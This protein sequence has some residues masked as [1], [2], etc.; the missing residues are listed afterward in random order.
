MFLVVS[1]FRVQEG[2]AD[3]VRGAFFDRPQ[4]V[5]HAPG[6]LGM[7]VFTDSADPSVFHLVTRWTDQAS[8]DRWH[9]SEAYH[10]SVQHLPKG[11]KIVAGTVELSRLERLPPA[12][13]VLLSEIVADT[14]PVLAH[15][16][17]TSSSV[18]FLVA[19]LDGTIRV[20]NGAMAASL[21]V[22]ESDLSGRSLWE[23]LTEHDAT[24]VRDRVARADRNYEETFLLN[25]VDCRHCPFTLE[26]HC[27]VQPTY[28]VLLGERP[29]ERTDA[30]QEGWL[31][32]NN[33]LSLLAR[34]NARQNKELQEA[35]RQLQKALAELQDSHWH[36]KK[37]QE[38][39]PIC[40]DCG[41]VK[42][43]GK[44]EGVVEYLKQNALF[45]SHGYC[46]QCLARKAAEW[47]LPPGYNLP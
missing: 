43:G 34:E 31:E 39:L 14:G 46:P 15:C 19:A 38:V 32:L 26:C 42:A 45:L 21:G 27:D 10:V 9:K 29:R 23:V 24:L 37:L 30:I 11:M 13:G 36:L 28:F 20:A 6:F 33:Q 18:A 16:L 12:A 1:R 35:K 41:K 2:L 25:F 7:E 47:G 17:A 8:F 22:P 44:W 3:A 40:L 5:D 4:L